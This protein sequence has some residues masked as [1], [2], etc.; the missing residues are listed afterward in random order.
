EHRGVVR[1]IDD[2]TT[3]DGA[4]F[5]VM[6]LLEGET[7]QGRMLRCGGS[8]GA[9]EVLALAYQ[10]LDVVHAAHARGILHRDLKPDNL[11]LTKEGIVKVLDFGVARMAIPGSGSDPTRT[12]RTM[13]TPAFMAPEQAF[14]KMR[15]IEARSDL[16]SVGAT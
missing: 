7:L 10:V 5:L 6:E 2:D 8:L 12:G 16:W 3:E 15:E 9:R 14:G 11:F 1:V 4:P 13:G